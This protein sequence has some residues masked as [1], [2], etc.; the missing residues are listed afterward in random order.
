MLKVIQSENKYWKLKRMDS[1]DHL[2][3]YLSTLPCS[4]QELPMSQG[5]F[6]ICL[7][8][9]NSINHEVVNCIVFTIEN[10]DERITIFDDS[11]V[12]IIVIATNSA[13]YTFNKQMKE[14][15]MFRISSPI[16]TIG[17]IASS[18][19]VF[20]AEELCISFIDQQGRRCYTHN[21][22]FIENLELLDDG[23]KVYREHDS[24]CF[25]TSSDE[26]IC[27]D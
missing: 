20:V 17:Y 26:I 27:I 22:G 1:K 10:D 6:Y 3:R 5:E 14:V 23:L 13:V 19:M 24:I 2:I 9:I 11:R 16:S 4:S 21:T 12:G 15:D 8:S 18:C 7:L 25:A